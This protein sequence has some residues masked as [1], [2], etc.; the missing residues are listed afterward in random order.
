VEAHVYMWLQRGLAWSVLVARALCRQLHPGLLQPL[1]GST[2]RV[3]CGV[4]E[5]NTI[6]LLILTQFTRFE[7][8][9]WVP[10]SH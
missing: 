1:L 9:L 7:T 10:G 5:S 3:N 6:V 8:N 4:V 2:E